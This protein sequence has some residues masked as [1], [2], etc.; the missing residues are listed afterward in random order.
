[1]EEYPEGDEGLLT[2]KRAALVQK[3]FL[4]SMGK[5]LRLLD[6]VS[7]ESSVDLSIE[8][9]AVKQQANLY[10]A[11]IGAIYLDGGLHPCEQLVMNTI[12]SHRTEAWKSTNYKGRLIELCH[13]RRLKNPQFKMSNVTGPE[14]QRIFEVQI[15]IGDRTFA[16]GIGLSKKVAEQAAAQNAL[17]R[18]L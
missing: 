13:V 12:W 1:M 14:H 5:L 10:E 9:I 18:L 4:S 16:P 2:Q 3:D 8:K 17:D 11:I 15:E 7:I 6:Y